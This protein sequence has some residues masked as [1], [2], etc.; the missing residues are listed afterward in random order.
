LKITQETY[1]IHEKRIDSYLK[2]LALAKNITYNSFLSIFTEWKYRLW[3]KPRLIVRDFIIVEKFGLI[4][5]TIDDDLRIF[6]RTISKDSRIVAILQGHQAVPSIALAEDQ[7]VLV[8]GDSSRV[9]LSTVDLHLWR[10]HED[11]ILKLSS[12]RALKGNQ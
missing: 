6:V 8:S 5:Y 11:V 2:K 12:S 10:L 7:L 9:K 1:L 3:E 4:V